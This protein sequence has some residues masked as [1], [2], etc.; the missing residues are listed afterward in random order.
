MQYIVLAL[1]FFLPL[2]VFHFG[3]TPFEIPKVIV[4][5]FSIELLLLTFLFLRYDKNQKIKKSSFLKIISAIALLTFF[6]LLFFRNPQL[7]FGNVFRLQGIFLLWHLLLFAYIS[8]RISKLTVPRVIPILSMSLI[9]LSIPL[10]GTNDS[11]RFIGTLGEPNALAATI[12]FL[13]P[14]IFFANK[15]YVKIFALV[16]SAVI[17]LLT[18]SSSGLI[19]FGIQLL[20]VLLQ[21]FRFF[22]FKQ[23]L[24]I[25]LFATAISYLLPFLES[26]RLYENR[27]EIWYTALLSGTESPFIGHGFGNIQKALWNT[28]W[29]INNNVQFQ[30]VD[31]SHNIFLDWW[32]QSG[33]IGTLL[34]T[35]LI[36]LAFINFSRKKQT[37]ETIL[38]LGIITVLSFNPASVASLVVL[39]WTIGRSFS[40]N[41]N[42][43]S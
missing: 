30:V 42:E 32:I 21:R 28:S 12:V 31:S 38:F 2:L 37:L 35:G 11:G 3:I 24:L 29:R 16:V 14:F 15:S 33:I 41:E 19:A 27:A 34:F 39:W 18:Q 5:E 36:V 8:S 4:A 9:V 7:F 25:A 10:F 22:S 40:D 20:F 6:Q 17:I 13:W 43:Y 1:L 26:N 23:T